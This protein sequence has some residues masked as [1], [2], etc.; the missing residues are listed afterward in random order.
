MSDHNTPGADELTA[1]ARLA[2]ALGHGTPPPITTDSTEQA[3]TETTTARAPWWRRARRRP[4]TAPSAPT[5]PGPDPD[6]ADP[7]DPDWDPDWDP[8]PGPDTADRDPRIRRLRGDWWRLASPDRGPDPSEDA[9]DHIPDAPGTPGAVPGAPD[10]GPDMRKAAPNDPDPDP[11]DADEHPAVDEDQDEEP[12]AGPPRPR[13]RGLDWSP[14]QAPRARQ[15]AAEWWLGFSVANSF[16]LLNG[17]AVAAGTWGA[18]LFTG[19]W[20]TGIPQLTLAA[21]HDAAAEST[22][23]STPL[24][25]GGLIVLGSA[26]A[27]AAAAGFALRIVGASPTFAR[28]VHWALVRV[29]VASTLT[30]LCLYTTT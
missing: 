25:L 28:F 3:N 9:P 15:S 8:D 14:P 16:L 11:A 29:P 19:D 20:S 17:S 2:A 7:V 12:A 24:F 10:L 21:M 27:G 18:G 22:S 26:I 1:R 4:D 13:R 5:A 30:A 23:T 6:S